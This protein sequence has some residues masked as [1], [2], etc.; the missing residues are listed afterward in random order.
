MEPR[1][2]TEADLVPISPDKLPEHSHDDSED[3][4]NH[5]SHAATLA[6]TTPS[7]APKSILQDATSELSSP[8]T[9]KGGDE[10]DKLLTK[11]FRHEKGQG[12]GGKPPK[13][14]LLGLLRHAIETYRDHN[15]FVLKLVPALQALV[16][17][18][19]AAEMAENSSEGAGGEKDTNNEPTRTTSR[20]PSKLEIQQA[21]WNTILE[22]KP[23]QDDTFSLNVTLEQALFDI[24]Q[25]FNDASSVATFGSSEDDEPLQTLEQEIESEMAFVYH[26]TRHLGL[27]PTPSPRATRPPSASPRDRP[28][29]RYPPEDFLLGCAYCMKSEEQ[30]GVP[31]TKLCA[32][33]LRGDPFVRYCS[34]ECQHKDWPRHRQMCGIQYLPKKDG[35]DIPF[36]LMPGR[37]I[38]MHWERGAEVVKN[39]YKVFSRPRRD[40]NLQTYKTI[41]DAHRCLDEVKRDYEPGFRPFREYT[42]WLG[43]YSFKRLQKFLDRTML[44]ENLLT[45]MPLW[46]DKEHRDT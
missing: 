4:D 39:I 9:V 40:G 33:C 10:T 16:E 7:V 30:L 29:P 41:I 22:K 14:A 36:Q 23:N 26:L 24:E 2:L 6:D 5:A 35:A 12:N 46:W 37:T 25:R 11:A 21:V 34:K 38:T 27:D 17:D 8:E 15:P 44:D 1:L 20:I 31:L 28:L 32:N 13:T 45:F 19:E 18:E 3:N 42:V 43:G